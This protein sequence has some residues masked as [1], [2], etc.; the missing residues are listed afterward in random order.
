MSSSPLAR[1]HPARQ[2]TIKTTIA[3]IRTL[4]RPQDDGSRVR[5][6][7]GIILAAGVLFLLSTVFDLIHVHRVAY[8][9]YRGRND[10][11][12]IVFMIIQ[13]LSSIV[14]LLLLSGVVR[15]FVTSLV[16]AALGVC[17]YVFIHLVATNGYA[18][19]RMVATWSIVTFWIVFAAD[20]SLSAGFHLTNYLARKLV[21]QDTG[22]IRLVGE[23]SSSQENVQQQG[24]PLFAGPWS[25]AR[26][27]LEG[28]KQGQH[29]S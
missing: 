27:D 28:G 2:Q 7:V 20:A 18:D 12:Y 14:I 23:N 3:N 4:I 25:D 26:M 5:A 16:V 13:G 10:A 6:R 17:V 29:S 8:W 24:N 15:E 21:E 22:R 19:Q 9:P 11:G 1:E